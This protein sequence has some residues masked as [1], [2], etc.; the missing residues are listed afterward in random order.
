[1]EKIN[2]VWGSVMGKEGGRE[3]GGG[4]E[5]KT[6][7]GVPTGGAETPVKV[8]GSWILVLPSDVLPVGRVTE[9]T[10]LKHPPLYPTLCSCTLTPGA[11]VLYSIK[12]MCICLLCG[13]PAPTFPT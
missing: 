3:G 13:R 12:L 9:Q 5:R 6:D 1:M 10:L 7:S 2:D 8:T 11:N 4:E